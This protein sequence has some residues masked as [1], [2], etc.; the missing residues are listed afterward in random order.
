V[1]YLIGG[2]SPING[3]NIYIPK[4]ETIAKRSDDPK[5]KAKYFNTIRFL[6]H[7]GVI[8]PVKAEA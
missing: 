7:F 3:Q 8:Q 2:S 5:V 4:L 6:K 1:A